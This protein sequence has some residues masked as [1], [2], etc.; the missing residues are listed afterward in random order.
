MLNSV[1]YY[2]LLAYAIIVSGSLYLSTSNDDLVLIGFLIYC[3]FLLIISHRRRISSQHLGYVILFILFLGI[4]YTINGNHL[5]FRTYAGMFV[6]VLASVIAY[7]IIGKIG[8][9][10]KY[11]KIMLWFSIIN[12]TIYL[13]QYYLFQVFNAIGDQLPALRTYRDGFVY[14]NF[15]FFA[16]PQWHVIGIQK[17]MGI[18]GE[19]GAFQ[20]FISIALVFNLF[21]LKKNIA[22]QSSILFIIIL[23]TTFSTIAY[24]SLAIIVYYYIKQYKIDVKY[25]YI[26][27]SLMFVIIM[28][29][30]VFNKVIS[31]DSYSNNLS[32]VRRMKDLEVDLKIISENPMF[33]I[34]FGRYDYWNNVSYQMRGGTSSSNGIS[35]YLAIAGIIGFAVAFY[36]L[37]Y[38]KYYRND[39][40]LIMAIS[41]ITLFSQS[42]LM[43]SPFTLMVM[44]FLSD[45]RD[46]ERCPEYLNLAK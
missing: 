38:V 9:I 27:Y 35:N 46:V 32:T 17:N 7:N 45:N 1:L 20:F 31:Q 37:Y 29:D 15:I 12:I 30:V 39:N 13:D 6:K 42:I 11:V 44:L 28:S 25:K 16:K 40:K 34:G 41:F 43:M 19:G 5:L 2:I 26:L 23:L 33:G 3:M 4:S 24:L 10:E 22:S 36:P 14:D 21:Y 8:F 18:F